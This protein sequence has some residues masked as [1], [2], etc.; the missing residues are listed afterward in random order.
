MG[1]VVGASEPGFG[2]V[3]PPELEILRA[4]LADARSGRPQFVLVQ[5][6]RGSGKSAYLRQLSVDQ[7]DL[8]VLSATGDEAEAELRYGLVEHLTRAAGKGVPEEL[9]GLCT[10][11]T[12]APDAFVVGHAL[13]RLLVTMQEDAPVLVVV[14]DADLTDIDSQVA[15]LF[16]LRRLHDSRILTVLAAREPER[17]LDGIH[18]LAAAD[19][20]TTITL[21]RLDDGAVMGL[22]TSLIGRR[23]PRHFVERLREHTGGN[24]SHVRAVLGELERSGAGMVVDDPLP[25]PRAVASLVSERLSECVPG[26]RRLVAA[27]A[28][29]G[30]RSSVELV[31]KL[32]EIDDPLPSL[33]GAVGAGLVEY[34]RRE[35][36][37]ADPL[38]RA[39]VYHDLGVAE[40][41][42]LHAQAARLVTEEGARLRHLTAAAF[43]HDGGLAA[44]L[45]DFA[46]RSAA[47]GSPLGASASFV[48]AADLVP[49][50]P[51]RDAYAFDAVD[52]LLAAGDAAG[53]DLVGS[54]LVGTR[55]DPT[56]LVVRG[57]IARVGGQWEEAERLLTGARDARPPDDA[58]HQARVADELA[59]LSVDLLRP[60]EGERWADAAIG[61]S[62][63]SPSGSLSPAVAWG[64]VLAGRSVDALAA[65][66]VHE[67]TLDESQPEHAGL[68]LGRVLADLHRGAAREARECAV[69]QVRIAA[70]FGL[71]PLRL[72][73]LAM[74]SFAEYRLG[75]WTEATTHADHGSELA[76]AGGPGLPRTMLHLAAILPLAGRGQWEAA[77]AHAA[78]GAEAAATPF[79]QAL[80][81][82]G[83]ATL[84]HAR[85]QHGKATTAV[86]SLRAVCDE[87]AVDE[88]GG[89]WPWQELQVD[90]LIGL[91]RFDDADEVLGQ[92]ESLAEARGSVAAIAVAARLRGC[93]EA[94]K[95]SDRQA[96]LAFTRAQEVGAKV[97]VPFERARTNLEVGAFL[98][99]AGKRTAAAA[100]L[101]S[102]RECFDRLGARPYLAR[103]DRELA[104][105]GLTPQRR[106]AANAE[107]LTPQETS[108]AEL[109][110]QGKTNRGVASELVVSVNTIEYHLKNIYAK[111]GISSRSQLTLR[112]GVR[113]A[114][115]SGPGPG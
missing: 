13:L 95:G 49:P 43:D 16:A 111:L 42:E 105:A 27:A 22:T 65:F 54:R 114:T 78:K 50:G 12:A 59:G 28:V 81:W 102:A 75:W 83:R 56:A 64:L 89:L 48:D 32:A 46:A 58:R 19:H 55:S 71:L 90:A 84:A 62:A 99:R 8:R 5:G 66:E 53:A 92:F 31:R 20:G 106:R 110:A 73:G 69:Q 57:R 15:L 24:P 87:G 67:P 68:L 113:T 25:A 86:A 18:K 45:A 100:E 30:Q 104:A 41:A 6:E 39:A 26:V 112:F 109:V 36:V 80:A 38:V 63:G 33:E 60:G 44:A 7:S 10:R 2:Y 94:A 1:T 35:V 9:A 70:R 40:R 115:A 103:C 91:S 79:D 77:E 93:L 21:R 3:G 61:I 47:A 34:R 51:V 101:R 96:H 29:L 14:D 76:E 108:V 17:L 85:G 82:M 74:L 37:F 23:P 88:P 4:M 72:C 107:V 11:T 52:C 98:R 97:P